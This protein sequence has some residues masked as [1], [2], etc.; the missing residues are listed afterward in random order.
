MNK[1]KKKFSMMAFV[2]LFTVVALCSCNKDE[3]GKDDENG[4]TSKIVNNTLT[5]TVENGNS[6]N[7]TIHDVKMYVN[8]TS[9]DGKIV[10]TSV[11][12]NNGGFT[13]KLPETIDDMYFTTFNI[14]SAGVTISDPNVKI[15]DGDDGT[16]R[17][18]NA[19]GNVIGYFKHENASGGRSV[20]T[21]VNADV[22][23][24]G[25]TDEFGYEQVKYDVELKKG[26]NIIY[27]Q[28]SSVNDRRVEEISNKV[29]AGLKWYYTHFGYTP[30]SSVS[31][32][33]P[34]LLSKR[35][36][37]LQFGHNEN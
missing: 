19:S 18:C 12:Y 32:K 8:Y 5:V 28:V 17:A 36:G 13:L 1:M 26:W 25:T 20:L 14:T 2:S 30:P 27:S 15:L 7:E 35:K 34:A 23:I 21:Y 3:D 6:F 9:E 31:Y 37:L 33:V 11:P 16:I 29:P 10:I 24:K 22:S 4:A